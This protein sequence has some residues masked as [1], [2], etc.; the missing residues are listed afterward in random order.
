MTDEILNEMKLN[1]KRPIVFFDLE[2]TGIDIAKD[3]IVEICYIKLHPNGSEEVKT[4]RIRPVDSRGNTVHIP[5]K[6]SEVH[7]IHDEDVKDCPTFSEVADEILSVIDDADLGGYNSNLFDIP[8]LTEEFLRAGKNID[9]NGKHFVDVCVIFKKMEQRTLSAACKFYLNKELE[10]AHSALADT[11][12]TVEVLCSQ[13]DMY[14]GSLENDIESL[15]QFSKL[16]NSLD[17]SGKIIEDEKGNAIFNFGKYKGKN[18]KETI[19]R[20]PG[21]FNWMMQ[22]DFPLYTKQVIKKIMMADAN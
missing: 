21:Y 14:A 8:M 2:T 16:N 1:L 7:G 5:E 11:R 6:A 19:S 10:N 3:H 12:A 22:G 15:S 18:V 13:L 20:D 17:L 9:M 4:M